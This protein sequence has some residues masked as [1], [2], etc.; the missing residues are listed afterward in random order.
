[1][2]SDRYFH[3]ILTL[4]LCFPSMTG[5]LSFRVTQVPETWIYWRRSSRKMFLKKNQILGQQSRDISGMKGLGM[6]CLGFVSLRITFGPISLLLV[7]RHFLKCQVLLKR[8][9]WW[10]AECK[11]LLGYCK[12]RV[13][14]PHTFMDVAVKV[15]TQIGHKNT[16]REWLL[17]WWY[18]ERNF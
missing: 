17:S 7:E 10:E 1:M 12:A 2:L 15:M 5:V 6:V 13:I 9:P 8:A 4:L 11:A 18:I 14:T 16:I 3:Y